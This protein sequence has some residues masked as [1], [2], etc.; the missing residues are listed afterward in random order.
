MYSYEVPPAELALGGMATTAPP[1]GGVLFGL[2]WSII[3]GAP[4]VFQQTNKKRKIMRP[5]CGLLLYCTFCEGAMLT[6][7]FSFSS[8]FCIS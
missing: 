1:Q 8:F 4:T 6:F 7:V 2:D 5:A 3:S